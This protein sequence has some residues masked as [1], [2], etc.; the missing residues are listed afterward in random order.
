[1]HQ[2]MQKHSVMPEFIR[3]LLV[4][5]QRV[6]EVEETYCPPLHRKVSDDLIGTDYHIRRS[7]TCD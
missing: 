6:D 4:F 1:M 3:T 7:E 5:R 2:I